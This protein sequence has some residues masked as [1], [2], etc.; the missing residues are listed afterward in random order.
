MSFFTA[1][2]KGEN[3]YKMKLFGGMKETLKVF[4]FFVE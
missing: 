4:P 3:V 2:G 1:W